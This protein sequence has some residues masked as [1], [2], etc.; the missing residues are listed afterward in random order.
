[1]AL[2]PLSDTPEQP[3]NQGALDIRGWGIRTMLDGE[4]VGEVTDLLVDDHGRVRYLDLRL[5]RPQKQILLPAER[6]RVDE[7]EHVVWMTGLGRRYLDRI[8]AYNDD[9]RSVT[10][11]YEERLDS[12]YQSIRPTKASEHGAGRL[13]SYDAGIAPTRITPPRPVSGP[14][15]AL[16][17]INGY[18]VAPGNIDPRGWDL[19]LAD[20]RRAGII[21]D[22][23]IE[24]SALKVRYLDTQLTL[25]GSGGRHI[26][27]PVGYARLEANQQTA[28]IDTM[29]NSDLSEVPSFPG[30][31]LAPEIERRTIEVFSGSPIQEDEFQS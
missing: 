1:M 11:E 3:L 19:V 22:L 17:A 29:T 5:N 27:V 26:L 31:P 8:P 21:H 10:P 18:E 12:A 9:P 15:A 24:P 14:L 23:V 25:P 7:A 6:A 2:S 16:S 30:L 20:Q 13:G 4:L 28:F